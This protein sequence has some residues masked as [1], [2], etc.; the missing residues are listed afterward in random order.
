[1]SFREKMAWVM[2]VS[3][4]AAA[5][6]YF[7]PM[8]HVVRA[9][10]FIAPA[11]A[12]LGALAVGLLVVLSVVGAIVAALTDVQSANAVADERERGIIAAA[13]TVGAFVLGAG[14]M[15]IVV[16]A[17]M[18]NEADWVVPALVAALAGSQ[19]IAYLTQIVLYRTR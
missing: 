19:I 1:M 16:L 5:V 18:L 13:E 3:L 2:A 15:L 11:S 10:G 14:V 12:S 17:H 8:W 9:G 6:A 7:V 4:I